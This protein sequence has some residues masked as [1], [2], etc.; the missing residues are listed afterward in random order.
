MIVQPGQEA[1][2]FVRGVLAS[3][4]RRALVTLWNV[5]D[6]ATA[7]WF[8]TL[9]AKLGNGGTLDEGYKQTMIEMAATR[10]HPFFWASLTMYRR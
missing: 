5:D 7:Q 3:G 8:G 1:I 4:A 9:Y 6:D 2:G 10:H